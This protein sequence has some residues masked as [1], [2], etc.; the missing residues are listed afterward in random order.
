[1]NNTVIKS[2]EILKLISQNRNGMTLSQIVKS[3]NLPKST[4]FNIV[5]TLVET[6]MLKSTGDSAPVYKLGVESLRLGLSYLKSSS[7]DTVARPILY[8]LGED[9]GETACMSVRTGESEVVYIMHF[10]S[11]RIYHKYT[12]GDTRHILSLAMGK[13]MLSAMTDD[14]ICSVITPDMLDNCSIPSVKDM[15]S[16]LE[17]IHNA[18]KIGYCEEA[19]DENVYFA[20]PVAAPV[21]GVDG[22]LVGAISLVIMHDADNNERIKE[23]GQ[24]VSAAALEISHGLGYLGSSLYMK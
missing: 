12:V 5:H 7:I 2:V 18:Q 16:L 3:L 20:R 6:G 13:A 9:T 10:P 14:E 23:L 15:P 17:Y 19:T 8:K 4:V 22:A 1:M 24:R 21:L 11:D